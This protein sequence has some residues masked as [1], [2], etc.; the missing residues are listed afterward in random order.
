MLG[1]FSALIAAPKLDL[2]SNFVP[3]S[4]TIAAAAAAAALDADLRSGREREREIRA[5]VLFQEPAQ[6]C[7]SVAPER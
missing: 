2:H 7:R 1:P 6:V 3:N 4:P 5:L